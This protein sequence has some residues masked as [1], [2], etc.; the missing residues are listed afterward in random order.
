MLTKHVKEELPNNE[1]ESKGV[2]NL[3]H[4]DIYGLML[5]DSIL[6]YSYFVTFIDDYC[7]KTW[8]SFM[9][10]KDEAFS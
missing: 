4:S 6:G 3:V 1:T 10:S 9:K 5:V 2:L 7:R 8:I